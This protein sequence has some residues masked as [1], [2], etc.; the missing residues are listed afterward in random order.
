[1]QKDRT[2]AVLWS[3][4]A[5][6]TRLFPAA[7]F[8]H[9]PHIHLTELQDCQSCHTVKPLTERAS[10]S[11]GKELVASDLRTT[12]TAGEFQTVRKQFCASCHLPHAAGD[13]CALCH[14]YHWGRRV[15]D[16][17]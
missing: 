12:S 17:P 13:S 4:R 6:A 15:N 8:A 2:G 1:L 3:E 14:R 16:E 7:R 10:L 9:R 11:G 5:D